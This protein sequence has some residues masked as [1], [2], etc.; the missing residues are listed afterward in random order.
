[1]KILFFC[2]TIFSG[3]STFAKYNSEDFELP[4]TNWSKLENIEKHFES[5]N[6]AFNESFE[7]ESNSF[8]IMTVN[9]NNWGPADKPF[10]Y[11]CFFC[12]F[13]LVYVNS[14]TDGDKKASMQA[15]WGCFSGVSIITIFSIFAIEWI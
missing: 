4:D 3:F 15:L 11:G 10:L 7:Y 12:V 6:L 14:V 9:K 13:G 2:L 1:M 5:G 8:L